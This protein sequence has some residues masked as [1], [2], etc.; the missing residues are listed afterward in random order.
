VKFQYISLNKEK[1]YITVSIEIQ[2]WTNLAYQEWLSWLFYSI[3]CSQYWSSSPCKSTATQ[4]KQKWFRW[5]F[6]V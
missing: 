5:Y 6:K 3:H 2:T 1:C 4:R